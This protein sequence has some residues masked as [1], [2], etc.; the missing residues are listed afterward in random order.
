[1]GKVDPAGALLHS[2]GGQQW[3]PCAAAGACLAASALRMAKLNCKRT[4]RRCAAVCVTVYIPMYTNG[5]WI[6]RAFF[7]PPPDFS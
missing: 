1:M 3:H 6:A 2:M 4:N 5:D 7:E